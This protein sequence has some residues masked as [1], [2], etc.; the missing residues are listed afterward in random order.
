MPGEDPVHH[1]KLT[2]L[3]GKTFHAG[4]NLPQERVGKKKGARIIYVKEDANLVKVI[5]VGGHKDKRYDDSFAQ[6]SLVEGR[7]QTESYLLYTEDFE[8]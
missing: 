3:H 7:Y 8:F 2:L 6:V 5:Y 1:I 4:I